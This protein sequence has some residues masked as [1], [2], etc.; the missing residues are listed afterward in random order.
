[1]NDPRNK[2]T[3]EVANRLGN[4]HAEAYQ[5]LVDMAAYVVDRESCLTDWERSFMDSVSRYLDSGGF[6]SAKQ[7]AVLRKLYAKVE[8]TEA[9]KE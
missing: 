8:N 3:P 4:A 5:E 9:D 7:D 6:L 1:M 2:V